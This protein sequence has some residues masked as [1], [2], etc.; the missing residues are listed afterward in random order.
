MLLWAAMSRD[1]QF[2]HVSVQLHKGGT[3]DVEVEAR[4]VW[5][6]VG[7]ALVEFRRQGI[8]HH[9]L[10][11]V[12]VSKPVTYV[13]SPERFW[14]WLNREGER[15]PSQDQEIRDKLR[16]LLRMPLSREEKRQRNQR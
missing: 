8:E 3:L 16:D 6:A 10:M 1:P 2:C 13:A 14:R 15:K 4:T 7:L 12:T 5:E 9:G 11:Q